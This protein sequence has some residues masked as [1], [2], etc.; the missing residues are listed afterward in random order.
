[1]LIFANGL[2]ALEPLRGGLGRGLVVL[3]ATAVLCTGCGDA[4]VSR[5]GGD[6]E[7]ATPVRGGTLKVVGNS[8]VDHLST[9][10]GYVTGSMWL[11]R[12]FARQ[13]VT[14]P[15]AT[16]FETAISLE[17]DVARELPTREN[18]GVSADGLI[19]TLHLKDGIRWNSSPVRAVT[20]HDFARAFKY[21]C[22]PVSPVGAPGY[23]TST[24]VGMA[25]YCTDFMK[26][27]GTTADIRRFMTT[28]EIDGVRAIDAS[29]IVFTLRAPATDFLNLLAMPFA[30]AVPEEYLDYLPDSPDFRRNTLSNGPYAVTRYVQNRQIELARNPAWNPRADPHRPAYVDRISIRLGVDDELAQLQ[31]E[32]G[33]ADLTMDLSMLTANLAS[34]RA[35]NDPRV[36][37]M[38]YG[39]RYDS[40]H[41]L[42]INQAGPN[43]S[44][45][46]RN[47]KVRQAIALAV[48]K[49]AVAQ[50]AGGPGV[51]RPLHQAVP[52]S[53]SGFRPGADHF[54]TTNDQGDPSAARRL[55]AEAGFPNGIKLR[56]AYATNGTYPIES[57]SVQASLGRAGIDV[58]LFPFSAGDLWGRLLA[59]TQNARRGEWD[60]AM[61]GWL[62]DWFGSNNGRSVIVPLF[63]GRQVGTITQNYGQY[64]SAHVNAA[65]DRAIAAPRLDEAEAAWFDATTQVMQ[66]L[67]IV[68]VIEKK[69]SWM[70]SSRVRNCTWTIMGS[71][72]DLTTVWLSDAAAARSEHRP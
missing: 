37:L 49:R 67:A 71:Q 7:S 18:G 69:T 1:V 2:D 58:Q 33:T 21:F 68:P 27:P 59:N 48:N 31:I 63:D 43:N 66:D 10:S 26:V 8:D 13:L 28:H 53:V 44:G 11:T 52:S 15:P 5:Y 40:M 14:Y 24:I 51:A 72:C 25:R 55:L 45:A 41:Y 61:T 32:A 23:Y 12:T 22:N 16:D 9:V 19:Y 20:A 62:P 60:I 4:E 50:V 34:L 70:R 57:Q 29:T 47:F 64:E 36:T 65:I 3:L 42:A 46:L 17:P 6:A 54:R 39:D 35:I 38:P 56:F 30:S